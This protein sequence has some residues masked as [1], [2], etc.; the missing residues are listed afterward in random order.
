[1]LKLGTIPKDAF[2]PFFGFASLFY[3]GVELHL[4]KD[5]MWLCAVDAS[6]T[7]MIHSTLHIP[8]EQDP[9]NVKIDIDE[10][11]KISPKSDID[12]FYEENFIT[13]SIDGELTY[14][15]RLMTDPKIRT[16]PF[17]KEMKL[18]VNITISQEKVGKI[19]EL[20]TNLTSKKDTSE[21]VYLIVKNGQFIVEN[22]EKTREYKPTDIIVE[23]TEANSLFS[24]DLL[25][26]CLSHY[27]HFD[28]FQIKL[29]VNNP[30]VMTLT[31]KYMTT[32]TLAAP[33]IPDED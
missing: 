25:I 5:K 24:P 30:F 7:L 12:F 14:R 32:M 15:Q 11:T 8:I 10:I 23:G 13:F 9:I 21:K 26:D 17:P 20:L 22:L 19:L 28:T 33:R 1:M 4:E 31:N 6:N 27:K 3:K 18:P 29:G 16:S 2:K